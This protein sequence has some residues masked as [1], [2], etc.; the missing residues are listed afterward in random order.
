MSRASP[1]FRSL[2]HLPI[3]VP[4]ALLAV[5]GALLLAP[6]AAPQDP[7]AGAY[8]TTL[9][10]ALERAQADLERSTDLASPPVSWER[11]YEVRSA[12]YLVRT[13][14]SALLGRRIANDLELM[15][16]AFVKFFGTEPPSGTQF[17]VDIFPDLAAYNA[18]GE[19]FGDLH[20]S[21]YGSFFA[22]TAPTPCI[23]TYDPANLGLLREWVTHSAVH[24][25]LPA[26]FRVEPPVWMSEGLASCFAQSWAYEY[27]AARY[28]ELVN[29]ERFL[30]LTQLIGENLDNYDDRRFL[31]IGILFGYLIDYHE[32]TC[33]V[34]DPISDEVVEAPFRDMLR[35]LLRGESVQ[36]DPSYRVI[37]YPTQEFEDSF[38]SF[39]LP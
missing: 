34:L 32:S 3:P 37:R 39:E 7:A 22:T 6:T 31:E 4:L 2:M 5:G 24:Q 36:S 10:R 33:V 35:R 19:Q 16:E 14:R 11:A 29:T 25:F 12:H 9:R 28:L 23:A 1:S 26:C 8:G 38:K 21:R 17:E 30:P 13:T 15:Y 20:S 18:F 27:Y